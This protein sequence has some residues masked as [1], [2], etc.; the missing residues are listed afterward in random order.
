[1]K[2]EE[3]ITKKQII[4]MPEKDLKNTEISNLLDKKFEVMIINMFTKP[5]R[6]EYKHSEIFKKEIGNIRTFI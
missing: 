2:M 4:Q 3:F 1:M 6:R 5:L